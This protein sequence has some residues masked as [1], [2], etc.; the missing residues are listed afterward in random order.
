MRKNITQKRQP[1]GCLLFVNGGGG[2]ISVEWVIALAA[3]TGV[4]NAFEFPARNSFLGELVPKESLTSAVTLQSVAF[5]ATRAIGSAG[6]GFII[7]VWGVEACFL[8]NGVSYIIGALLCYSIGSV[9]QK[10][11]A[12]DRRSS[13][14]LHDGIRYVLKYRELLYVFGIVASVSLFGLPFIPMLPIFADGV[15]RAGVEGLG[16]LSGVAG[17]GALIAALMVSCKP[18]I[19]DKERNIVT[20]A[21][22]FAFGLFM[23]AH[24][25]SIIAAMAALLAVGWGIVIMLALANCLIQHLCPSNMRGRIMAIFSFFVVGLAP[26]GHAFMGFIA[27]KVGVVKALSICSVICGLV[28]ICSGLQLLKKERITI[29]TKSF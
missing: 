26:V 14:G 28:I 7:A 15:L 5:N 13:K 25:S 1:V 21:G 16:L 22:I 29:S 23:F 9:K 17:L 10:E 4:V 27:S 20:S 11:T 2:N 12:C 3:T 6:A 19:E 24:S 18:E 8:L